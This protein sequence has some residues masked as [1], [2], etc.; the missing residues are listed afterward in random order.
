M[1]LHIN[2]KSF[3]NFI[4]IKNIIL[5]LTGLFTLFVLYSLFTLTNFND[6]NELSHILA[7]LIIGFPTGAIFKNLFFQLIHERNIKKIR[8]MTYEEIISKKGKKYYFLDRKAFDQVIQ[9]FY[10]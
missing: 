1:N 9:K 3:I 10:K 7:L 4:S 8:S 6:V 2:Y 5:L